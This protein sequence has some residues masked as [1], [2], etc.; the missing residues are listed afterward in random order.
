MSVLQDMTRDIMTT[1]ATR[2]SKLTAVAGESGMT[3]AQAAAAIPDVPEV[4]LTNEAVIDIARDLRKQAASLIAI[5]DALDAHT[6]APSERFD[7]KAHAISEQKAAEKAADLKHAKPDDGAEEFGDRMKRLM[8]EA[9]AATLTAAD[10]DGTA[11]E[12]VA[13]DEPTTGWVCPDHGAKSLTT[14]NPRKGDPYI[15]CGVGDCEQYEK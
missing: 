7:A 13:P 2:A 9:Q 11:E 10:D 14:V 8:E 4:F 12:P 5:A 1:K 6:G 3:V 15:M